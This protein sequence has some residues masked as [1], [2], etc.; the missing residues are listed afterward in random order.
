MRNS[1]PAPV[2]WHP[3]YWPAWIGLTLMRLLSALPIRL[4]WIVGAGLGEM[5]YLLYGERR[6]IVHINLELCFPNLSR[7]ERRSLARSHFRTFGQ[8]LLSIGI[9]WWAPAG[10]LERAVCFRGREHFSAALAAGRRVILF[11][12]HFVAI[13][14]GGLALSRERPLCTMYRHVKNPLIDRV[15]YQARIR[16]GVQAIDRRTGFRAVIRQ[17]KRGMPFYYLPDQDLG[18]KHSVF[19]PFF[20]VPTATV[21]ALGRLAKIAD[22]VVIPCITRQ[23]P[24]GAG[25]EVIF[26]APLDN[27]PSGDPEADARRMNQEIE[28]AVLE[29]PEQY[30]WMHKRFKTRPPGEKRIYSDR[31]TQRRLARRAVINKP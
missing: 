22:A 17:L 29:F 28:K 3:R 26:K 7:R 15:T 6:R 23:L 20:G 12:P 11:V 19:V 1:A 5:L 8:S 25:Y 30:V 13:D 9:A 21:P 2:H 16:F 14:I 10:R 27:F 31:R 18:R 4:A 24:R